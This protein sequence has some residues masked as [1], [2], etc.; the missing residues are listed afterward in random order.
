MRRCPIDPSLNHGRINSPWPHCHGAGKT[1]R[2]CRVTTLASDDVL[3]MPEIGIDIP[4]LS[5]T[6]TSGGNRRAAQ[7]SLQPTFGS[8]LAA[9][10]GLES[11]GG[12][13]AISLQDIWERLI[14]ATE[15]GTFRA[16]HRWFF[17]ALRG[18]G[19][20][21]KQTQ[22]SRPSSCYARELHAGWCHQVCAMGRGPPR[23]LARKRLAQEADR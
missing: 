20:I 8:C 14:A 13:R 4:S 21:I 12:A 11:R 2:V 7:F 23:R 15:L 19:A 3:H 6:W 18:V 5:S 10:Q 22:Q 1:R 16:C 17:A 9:S